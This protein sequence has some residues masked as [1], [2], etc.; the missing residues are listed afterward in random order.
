MFLSLRK[1]DFLLFFF[2]LIAAALIAAVPLIRSEDADDALLVRV[3]SHGEL[4]G[5][6]PL[7]EDLEV[8]ITRD[9]SRNIVSIRD[10]SVQ[11]E[12]STCKNQVCVH[13]GT[14]TE[15][16]ETIVCLPNY[17]I[18]EIISNPNGGKGD[19]SIDAIVK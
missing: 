5:L 17:V 7:G 11:M 4:V 2:F 10:H 8:E 9:N 18:V 19:E 6:Y 14:I 13:T 12:Y 3:I 15:Q 1:P 16:G